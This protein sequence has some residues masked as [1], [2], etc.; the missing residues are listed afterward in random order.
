M[1]SNIAREECIHTE[2]ALRKEWIDTNGLGGYASST[3]LNCHTRQ[4][5]AEQSG[6]AADRPVH[7]SIGV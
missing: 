3:I 4:H 5:D 1:N 7:G 2:T 6:D